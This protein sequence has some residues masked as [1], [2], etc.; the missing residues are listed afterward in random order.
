MKATPKNTQ[1]GRDTHGPRVP[2]QLDD[3]T[4]ERL[5][6]IE[7]GRALH[8]VTGIGTNEPALSPTGHRDNLS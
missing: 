8:D 3:G 7:A 6:P 4:T 2:S 5:A 1:L